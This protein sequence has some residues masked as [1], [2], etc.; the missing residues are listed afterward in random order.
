MIRKYKSRRFLS[1]MS[2]FMVSKA[3]KSFHKTRIFPLNIYSQTSIQ[4]ISLKPIYWM[5]RKY[6]SRRFLSKVSWFL[7]SK[8]FCR[9]MRIITVNRLELKPAQTGVCILSLK[10]EREVHQ[11][12]LKEPVFLQY[13]I[14]IYIC[15]LWANIAKVISCAMLSQA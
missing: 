1:K 11:T 3:V 9:S 15:V 8:A 4:K 2:W 12:N 7:V 13:Y 10:Y 6:K 14:D 5:I